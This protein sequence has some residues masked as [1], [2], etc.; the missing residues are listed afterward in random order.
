MY[1]INLMTYNQ[2]LDGLLGFSVLIKCRVFSIRKREKK[3]RKVVQT[4]FL[5][6]CNKMLIISIGLKI[7][8]YY[9]NSIFYINQYMYNFDFVRT[10]FSTY[11]LL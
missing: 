2:N 1:Y 7:L 5:P 8:R 6:S 4:L 11:F 9:A 10:V 3:V